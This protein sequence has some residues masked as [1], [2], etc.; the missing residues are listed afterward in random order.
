MVA[1]RQKEI[2]SSRTKL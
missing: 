1:C 2:T